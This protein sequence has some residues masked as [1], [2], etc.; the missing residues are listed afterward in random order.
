MIFEGGTSREYDMNAGCIISE[1]ALG[2][3]SLL[4]LTR[5]LKP[6]PAS[7]PSWPDLSAAPGHLTSW[8]TLGGTRLDASYCTGHKGTHKG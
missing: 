5:T 3:V 2:G 8:I 4:R 7:L 6:Q 1:S